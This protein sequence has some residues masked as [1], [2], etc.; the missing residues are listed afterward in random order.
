MLYKA[1]LT[2]TYQNIL[3]CQKY[4]DT[5]NHTCLFFLNG[6]ILTIRFN[7]YFVSLCRY[8]SLLDRLCSIFCNM[9]DLGLIYS[10]GQGGHG[11]VSVFIWCVKLLLEKKILSIYLWSCNVL[12]IVKCTQFVSDAVVWNF[13]VF[14]CTS[15]F[16][17]FY[18]FSK[19]LLN[20]SMKCLSQC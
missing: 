13:A 15:Y 10:K 6:S 20:N 9:L 7:L 8:N 5:Q 17:H 18:E 14:Y 11:L 19:F 2:Q 3:H 16:V 1:V 4:V 12:V